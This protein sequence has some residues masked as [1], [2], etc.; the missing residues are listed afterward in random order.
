MANTRSQ[1]LRHRDVSPHA[2]N[3][4]HSNAVVGM[5]IPSSKNELVNQVG[6]ETGDS[7]LLMSNRG[8]AN[9]N[10]SHS[11]SSDH[12]HPCSQARNI[13][14]THSSIWDRLSGL[15]I[16]FRPFTIPETSENNLD[17]GY[18]ED[19]EFSEKDHEGCSN[20][21]LHGTHLPK[22]GC[23][24]LANV[25][26]QNGPIPKKKTMFNGRHVHPTVHNVSTDQARYLVSNAA[27][28][29]IKA[30]VLEAQAAAMRAQ[31]AALAAAEATALPRNSAMRKTGHA[32]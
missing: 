19:D 26:A 4:A 11:S 12:R 25:A 5:G 13:H 10:D 21:G 32:P 27:D 29:V 23:I 2:V 14:Q 17:S 16:N 18:Q 28:A 6:N 30:K 15:G 22:Q 20:L 3:E 8:L 1:S 9:S 24:R 31:A 7:R